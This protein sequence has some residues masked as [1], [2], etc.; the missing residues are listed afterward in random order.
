MNEATRLSEAFEG[1]AELAK[2]LV[3][4]WVPF[5][6]GVSAKVDAGTYDGDAA[7]ADFP[8]V[9]KLVADSW[10]AIGSEAIDALSILTSDFS[11]DGRVIGYGTDD[12]KAALTRTLVVKAAL[13]SVTGEVLPRRQIAVEPATLPEH[14]TEFTLVFDAHGLK[15]RTYDGHVVA[16]DTAGETEEIPVSVTIG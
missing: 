7:S 10:F 6:G 9:A 14:Q 16:T 4:Q 12:K 8:V 5:V 2:E 15:A 11:E 1:Y 3:D 13:E